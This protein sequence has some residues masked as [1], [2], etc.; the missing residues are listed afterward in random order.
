MGHRSFVVRR[1]K[2]ALSPS[3]RRVFPEWLEIAYRVS[4]APYATGAPVLD[5]HDKLRSPS[6]RRRRCGRDRGSCG[7]CDGVRRPARQYAPARGGR[8]CARVATCAVPD[9]LVCFGSCGQSV[10]PACSAEGVAL[11]LSLWVVTLVRVSLP[12]GILASS[13]RRTNAANRSVG[14]TERYWCWRRD[15]CVSKASVPRLTKR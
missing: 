5:V 9:R 7:R 14:M 2:P 4:G 1:G 10:P 12:S 8:A 15:I 11:R 13:R 3:A 6:P